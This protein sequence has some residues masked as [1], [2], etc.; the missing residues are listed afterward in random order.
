MS[1]KHIITTFIIILLSPQIIY[2]KQPKIAII[3]PIEH[4]S[5]LQIT[6]GIK[7]VLL[8]IASIAVESA[9][10]DQ[11]IQLAL[12]KQMDNNKIDV[13]MP[14]GTAA[15][16]MAIAHVK[17]ARIMCVAAKAQGNERVASLNDEII[18][19]EGLNKFNDLPF[20]NIALIYSPNEKIE[21]EVNN[22]INYAKSHD[23]KLFQSMINNLSELPSAVNA[24]PKDMQA[25][26]ILKDHL[27]VSGI[28]IIVKEAEKRQIPI[29]ASDEGSVKNGATIAFGAKEKEIGIES[30][31]IVKKILSGEEVANSKMDKISLFVNNKAIQKQTYITK[32][33]IEK[34]YM[35]IIE[36]N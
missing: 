33:H 7:E 26:L 16:Q 14:I 34:T 17:N 32:E 2:A 36:I 18:I 3:V 1:I 22:L 30:A 6:S 15:C 35:P 13:I 5:M 21:P 24:L 9:H 12:I 4:E 29:I 19:T 10:G 11:N 20:K 23:L 31:N 28:N 27:V 8:D 25:I